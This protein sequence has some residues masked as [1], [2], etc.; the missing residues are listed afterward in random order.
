MTQP[1]YSSAC[2]TVSRSD[3]ENETTELDDET[4]EGDTSEFEDSETDSG[5]IQTRVW[6]HFEDNHQTFYLAKRRHCT[7]W[8]LGKL[9]DLLVF[10]LSTGDQQSSAQLQTAI[11]TP[12]HSYV[13]RTNSQLPTDNAAA[14]VAA[15]NDL[16]DDVS[17]KTSHTFS[18][19]RGS[20]WISY[21]VYHAAPVPASGVTCFTAAIPKCLLSTRLLEL[22]TAHPE[23]SILDGVNDDNAETLQCPGFFAPTQKLLT[24][25]PLE[26]YVLS[27]RRLLA[28]GPVAAMQQDKTY[29][30]QC[31]QARASGRPEPPFYFHGAVFS[32]AQQNVDVPDLDA[33]ATGDWLKTIV[34][35]V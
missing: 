17:L 34:V 7:P 11:S 21:I 13:W 35:R 27:A 14:F 33:V 8:R 3:T 29:W 4:D 19:D 6:P 2:F 10:S 12:D 1:L 24:L 25:K 31:E 30:R 15:W 18:S 28:I 22:L 9:L 5:E 26:H 23:V 32:R 20:I 16:F